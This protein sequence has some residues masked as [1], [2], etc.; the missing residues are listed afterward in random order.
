MLSELSA[1]LG[2]VFPHCSL[3]AARSCRTCSQMLF[4]TLSSAMLVPPRPSPLSDNSHIGIIYIFK[5]LFSPVSQPL[6][7]A[8][9]AVF[10][11]PNLGCFC[12]FVNLLESITSSNGPDPVGCFSRPSAVCEGWEWVLHPTFSGPAQCLVPCPVVVPFA[13]FLPAVTRALQP[14]AWQSQW[15]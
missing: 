7:S 8:N 3:N 13:V 14:C 6:Y 10:L 12:L 11:K 2:A 4:P 15:G 9:S 5:S 1:H